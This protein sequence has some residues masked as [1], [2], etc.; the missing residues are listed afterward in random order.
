VIFLR[1]E[2]E[3]MLKLILHL[4]FEH[5]QEIELIYQFNGR[6]PVAIELASS[7]APKQDPSV[8]SIAA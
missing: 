2:Y 5:Q 8:Y 7:F 6:Y 4:E 3:L 1:G